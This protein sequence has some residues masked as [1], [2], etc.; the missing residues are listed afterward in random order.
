MTATVHVLS[1]PLE[2]E[3]RRE[4]VY[5][6]DLLVFKDVE[7]MAELCAFA[8]RLIREELDTRDPTKAQFRLGKGDY[9]ARVESLH[10]RFR[11]HGDAKRLFLAALERIGVDLGSTCWDWL[12]LRVLPS[13][14]EYASGRAA[15]LGFHRDTWSSNVYSQTNWWAPI[16]P[17]SPGRTLAF[18]LEYWS[19]PLKNTSGGWD[20]DEVRARRRAGEPV[21]LVPEPDEPVDSASELRVVVE[22]GDLLCFSGAHLHAAV[23]NATGLTRFSIEVRT[24]D[25]TDAASDRGV[26]NVDGAAPRVAHGWFR[27]VT[28]GRSLAE[29]LASPRDG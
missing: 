9:L 7:P 14:E 2:D 20:L 8:D 5:G 6:G 13:G 24:V 26:P 11:E 17:I 12:Y 10:K 19:R 23:P 4:L 27:H 22:P 29:L 15:K 18:Y 16:Y 21:A 28:S 25:A 1:A 3:R